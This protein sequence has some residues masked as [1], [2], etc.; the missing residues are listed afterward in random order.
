MALLWHTIASK[1]CFH[2]VQTTDGDPMRLLWFRGRNV[3]IRSSL[4]IN[5]ALFIILVSAA[6]YTVAAS[7]NR[8]TIQHL[9]EQIIARTANEVSAELSRIFDPVAHQL[10]IAEGW[11]ATGTLQPADTE[12]LNHLFIPFLRQYNQV[13]SVMVADEV[14]NEYL[15]LFD[16]EEWHNRRVFSEDAG[17]RTFWQRWSGDGLTLIDEEWRDLQYSPTAK[18]W[19]QGAIRTFDSAP[20]PEA[21]HDVF[22]TDPYTFF[23]TRDPGI[24]ASLAFNGGDELLHVAALDVKLIDISKF[25]TSLKPTEN[26][27]V[28]VYTDDG[29]VVGLPRAQ[30]FLDTAEQ[31]A[32]MFAQVAHLD[33]PQLDIAMGQQAKE[34][35]QNT[36]QFMTGEETWWAGFRR[37]TLSP[38]Q[39]LWIG[40]IIPERDFIGSP[41]RRL[42]TAASV[43]GVALILAML[44]AAI[45]SNRYSRPMHA[46]V[47]QARRI[48]NLDLEPG[49]QVRTQYRELDELSASMDEMRSGLSQ[50]IATRQRALDAL[51]K[52]ENRMRAIVDSASEAILTIDEN[53]TIESANPATLRMFGY[54]LEELIG[55][56]M[57][58]LMPCP[59]SEPNDGETVPFNP[60]SLTGDR[61]IER[62][63][64]RKD[65]AALLLS[66]SISEVRVLG[67]RF[68]T[69]M[70]SDITEKKKAEEVLRNYSRTLENEVA[71]RTSELSEKN[72]MLEDT[73]HELRKT[74]DQ[75]I[76]QEKLASLGSLTAGIAHEIKNPLNF[77]NN[78]AGLTNEL[79]DDLKELL[80]KDAFSPEHQAELDTLLADISSNLQKIGEH[81][82]RADNIVQGMLSHS[83]GKSLEPQKTDL[84]LLV[85]EYAKLAYHGMRAQDPNFQ[86]KFTRKLDPALKP[87]YFVPQNMA[88]VFLNLINNAC[89]AT[90]ER[91]RRGETDY[92]PR[93]EIA[94]EDAGD[95]AIVRIHDNGTGI[96]P[97]LQHRIFEPFFTT[98][99]TGVG[100]GLGLSMSYN[101]VVDEHGGKLELE[102]CEGDGTTFTVTLPKRT[103]AKA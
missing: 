70:I 45:L 103:S 102:S 54:T 15:L 5:F 20:L 98:K 85:D 46:L 88:R 53:G 31:Q 12:A 90:S 16:G 60:C 72:Q 18:P 6:V 64:R 35:G 92:R 44:A 11:T 97:D 41:Q 62:A 10:H 52:Q 9:S 50:E 59:D 86:V 87:F 24:T 73:L 1:L 32:E 8:Q 84:N 63:G 43:T 67:R 34:D 33:I 49:G 26:G 101:I 61:H 48:A 100:T 42:M 27:M 69:V 37:Y 2:T 65:G 89:Y 76:V 78:F 57:A 25:T 4:F 47:A 36:F 7:R 55:Q 28:I 99:P 19:W 29:E 40:I 66:A 56:N 30:R 71:E 81:G 58:T 51:R 83:R 82:S 23:T 21:R 95:T 38:E 13:S 75:L 3:T 91:A 96:P 77:V 94:T 22:W 93:V 14:G 39:S 17:G 68:F 80:K 74:Q 79:L